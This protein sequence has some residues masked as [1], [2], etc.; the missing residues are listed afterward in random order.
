M[1][2]VAGLALVFCAFLCMPAAA[3][4]QPR[5]G[6]L[7]LDE[8]QGDQYGW[9]VDY[10][11]SAA[12]RA[13]A[14]SEC[15]A[16]CSV[17]LTFNRCGAYAAD[18]DADSTAVG[19]AESFD[20]AAGARQAALA[21][22]RSRGGSG[23]IVRIWGCN[24]P[25]VE[26]G[27]GLDQAA[28]RQIQEGLEAAGFDPGVADG[29]LGPRTRAAIRRWQSSRGGRT[30]G[31]LD[32]AQVEA[33]RDR[34]RSQPLATASPPA[35]ATSSAEVEVVFWQ[36]I[37]NSTNPADFEAYLG[38]FPNGAFRPLAENRLTALREPASVPSAAD[39]TGSPATVTGTA[40]ASAPALDSPNAAAGE[41]RPRPGDVFRDCEVCPEM[42]VM[43]GGRLALGRYEVT[44]GEYRAFAAAT[45][46]E[47]GGGCSSLGLGDSWRDPGFLQTD[48]HPV[49]CVN[50]HDANTY[51]SW[52][53]QRTGATYRL[54]T[55]AEW[56]QAAAGSRLGCVERYQL[57]IDRREG[58]CEVGSHGAN[59]AGLSD[60]AGN[61]GE[62]LEECW[63]DD[64]RRRSVGSGDWSLNAEYQRPGRSGSFPTDLRQFDQG[65]RVARA[66][67]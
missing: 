17:V 20:S 23:C 60:M 29:L 62:W 35:S 6:A 61:V 13:A 26:E 14:L 49:T 22:C 39:G 50:W 48:Q 67:E 25:V 8:R 27:L 46:G 65:F 10:E 28:R 32:A 53:S 2:T 44:V 1:Q 5:A 38:Q 24:G 36:S 40:V 59:S 21:E 30:T 15:G 3:A 56:V 11:T 12:A 9:A 45:G 43:P 37:V 51:V 16:G 64:C 63:E 55:V 47:A 34:G 42:V 41:A 18:Q 58:T 4:A 33:L 19:W 31:Y 52:L 66:L 57:L 7:A 54:P